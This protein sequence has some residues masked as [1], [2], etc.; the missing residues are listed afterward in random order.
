ML[1]PQCKQLIAKDDW[2]VQVSYW[3]REANQVVDRL[4]N[5]GI[6]REGVTYYDSPPKETLDVLH[7]DFVG[8]TW[9]RNAK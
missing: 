1:I 3:Y 6:D 2:E 5:L 4:A 8:A 7:A 9:P